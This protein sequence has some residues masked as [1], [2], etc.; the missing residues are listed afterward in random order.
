MERAELEVDEAFASSYETRRRHRDVC[1]LGSILL[2]HLLI[3]LQHRG[4]QGFWDPAAPPL[5][6]VPSLPDPL[7]IKASGVQSNQSA[8][9]DD[10]GKPL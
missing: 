4:G 3:V 5:S 7:R 1:S 6:M 2:L 9:Y 10:F 8:I